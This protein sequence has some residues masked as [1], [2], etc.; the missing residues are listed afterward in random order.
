LLGSHRAKGRDCISWRRK[1]ENLYHGAFWRRPDSS[2]FPH[3]ESHE[4]RLHFRLCLARGRSAHQSLRCRTQEPRLCL[5]IPYCSPPLHSCAV[6]D[7]R[8]SFIAD[9][10]PLC[11][12]FSE[13]SVCILTTQ[14]YYPDYGSFFNCS[15]EILKFY[16]FGLVFLCNDSEWWSQRKDG[17][18][19]NDVTVDWP[20]TFIDWQLFWCFVRRNLGRCDCYDLG[21]SWLSSGPPNTCHDNTILML[22]YF[23]SESTLIEALCYKPEGRG[24]YSQWGHFIFS[25][26][27]ILP[28]APWPNGRLSF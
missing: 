15:C 24:F 2:N 16:M 26:N 23:L 3:R 7:L 20:I 14:R 1:G 25:V 12:F 6:Y 9:L 22:L 13:T 19:G 5:L 8:F 10:N 21:L 28:A 4:M 11:E 27:E 18:A 17:H